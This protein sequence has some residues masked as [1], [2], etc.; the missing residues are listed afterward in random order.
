MSANLKDLLAK[1]G[2]EDTDGK[3]YEAL[4]SETPNGDAVQAILK[5][6][7]EYSKPFLEA[8]FGQ[9][10]DNER[11]TWK[12][13]YL[14]D[15][16][17]MANKEFGNKLTNKEIEDIIADPENEGKTYQAV[18]T[19]IKA[20]TTS[21]GD[22]KQLQDMLDAANG[23]IGDLEKTLTEKDAK[24]KED[25]DNFVKTGKLTSALEAKLTQTLQGIT[26]MNAAAAAKL[27]RDPLMK[28]ALI[29]LNES[30]GLDLYDPSNPENKLKKSETE[31]YKFE[32]LVKDLAKEYDLPAAVSGG[33][34]KVDTQA[35][36]PDANDKLLYQNSALSVAEQLATSL[37]AD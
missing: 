31:L 9:R 34:K 15:A 26:S 12:G 6:S 30:E 37:M 36:A 19:A 25:F 11:K 21:T 27:L 8:D 35:P 20:K 28:K 17:R 7:H 13:K 16:A 1:L 4:T 22:N 18:I 32:D 24:H 29:K 23:K 5:K 2:V 10:L 14:Q 33:A 3:I